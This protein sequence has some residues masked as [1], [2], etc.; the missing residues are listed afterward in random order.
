MGDNI[1]CATNEAIEFNGLWPLGKEIPSLCHPISIDFDL[2]LEF[3]S[4]KPAITIVL[5]RLLV[6]FSLV[7][8]EAP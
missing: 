1:A 3:E 2:L 4:L 7:T 6:R 5:P 8:F